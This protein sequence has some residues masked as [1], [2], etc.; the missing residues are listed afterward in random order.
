MFY[1]IHSDVS[2]N[3]FRL[4]TFLTNTTKENI[5]EVSF[6]CEIQLFEWFF[7]SAVKDFDIST[8]FTQ[9]VHEIP[10]LFLLNNVSWVTKDLLFSVNFPKFPAEHETL[11]GSGWWNWLC[12]E[13]L[14]HA[15]YF[16]ERQGEE[17]SNK[18]GSFCIFIP[19]SLV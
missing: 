19:Q 17:F 9:L 3:C 8:I 10:V 7:I 16:H 5:S 14:R 11:L 18:V 6:C 12:W 4:K 1:K 13:I 15:D 2:T